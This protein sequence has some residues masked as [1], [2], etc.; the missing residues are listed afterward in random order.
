MMMMCRFGGGEETVLVINLFK[1]SL[2]LFYY[3][4]LLLFLVI[5]DQHCQNL[6]K[7]QNATHGYF[8]QEIP[9]KQVD[10]SIQHKH[11]YLHVIKQILYLT[12]I[13]FIFYLSF[14]TL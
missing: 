2:L 10:N 4:F 12:N 1:C 5:V 9:T 3:F 7:Q 14:L 8:F 13:I 6:N 11:I